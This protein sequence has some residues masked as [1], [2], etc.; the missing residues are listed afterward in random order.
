MFT[1]IALFVFIYAARKRRRKQIKY[2]DRS[3]VQKLTFASC[4]ISVALVSLQ[5]EETLKPTYINVDLSEVELAEYDGPLHPLNNSL[6]LDVS[7]LNNYLMI[8]LSTF[9]FFI[10]L[11]RYTVEA[12]HD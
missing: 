6:L 9:S 8:I 1:D 10:L 3:I 4:K 2:T 12:R 5:Y 11:C 7:I